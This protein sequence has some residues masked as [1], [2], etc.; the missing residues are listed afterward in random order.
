MSSTRSYSR[1][2]SSG[3]IVDR[4]C[5]HCQNIGVDSNHSLRDRSGKL[6]CPVLLNNV[7]RLCGKKG[8]TVSR[9]VTSVD[10]IKRAT[11]T[12][13]KPSTA[14][15]AT[16]KQQKNVFASL[17]DDDDEAAVIPLRP[18]VL[19]KEVLTPLKPPLVSGPTYADILVKRNICSPTSTPP[20]HRQSAAAA[21]VKWTSEDSDSD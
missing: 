15:T 12:Y 6:S 11:Q 10:S 13:V 8:H 5:K 14:T 16:P 20:R 17:M 4:C 9:C 18:R 19:N 1:S 7:C 21:V 2:T 3:I